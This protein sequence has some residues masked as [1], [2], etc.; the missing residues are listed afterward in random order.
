MFSTLIEQDDNGKSNENNN[1][2][3][4]IVTNNSIIG[5]SIIG[6]RAKSS[7]MMAMILGA[8]IGLLWVFFGQLI[9]QI[10]AECSEPCVPGSEDMMTPKAHGS[11]EYPVQN[12]SFD[13]GQSQNSYV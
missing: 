4:Y 12:V 10:G 6:K 1:V 8:V 3:N 13:T 9:H 7:C 5:R 11:S 2:N